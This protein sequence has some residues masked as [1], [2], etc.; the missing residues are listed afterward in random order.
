MTSITRQVWEILDSDITIRKDLER[1]IINVSALSQYLLD[2]HQISGSL[3]SVISAIRRYKSDETVQDDY[4][5]IRQALKEAV[6]STKTSISLITLKNTSNTYKYIGRIMQDD[7]FLKNEVFRL[8][9][10]RHDVQIVVDRDSMQKAKGY[11]PQTAVEQIEHNLVEISCTLTKHGWQTKGVLSRVANELA[12]QDINIE[13]TFSLYPTISIFIREKDLVR[14][15]ESL[16]RI[17]G[18]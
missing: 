13:L 5:R 4:K 10:R 18:R 3:D 1:G 9:K 16:L 15:H 14:A 17:S 12:T 8:L 7:D 11:F 2:T 6:I